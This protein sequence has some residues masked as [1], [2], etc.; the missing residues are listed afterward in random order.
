MRRRSRQARWWSGA[1]LLALAAC[2]SGPGPGNGDA[3]DASVETGDDG[4]APD[5]PADPRRI[6]A[7]QRPFPATAD[8]TTTNFFDH[9][10][11]REFID[12]NGRYVSY[13]GEDSVLGIDGH[14]GYDWRM[15]AGTS[16][17]AVMEGRV[18]AAG[19]S[20]PFDCPLLGK[21]VTD[22]RFVT[23]EHDLP[24]GV[25]VR[26][27]YIHLATIA[28]AA[29]AQVAAG[30]L[31][32]TVGASG[33]ALNPHLHF[34]VFRLTQT[35]SGQPAV[36]DPF[37]WSGAAADP[38]EADPAGAASIYLWRDGEAPPLYRRFDIPL[39][40]DA[41]DTQFVGITQIRFQGVDDAH[42]PNNEYVEISRDNRFAP[43]ALDLS[44]FTLK[45][46]AGDVF[47]FP[48]AFT[49]TAA[50]TSVRVFTGT[51]QNAESELYWGQSGPRLDNRA[52]CVQLFNAAGLLRTRTGWGGGCQ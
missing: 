49:L 44:G 1:T 31:I 25:R 47:T 41:G 22:Q 14:N 4:A 40:P 7:F 34:S 28:V 26:T 35:A 8:F 12:T 10:V 32:G 42:E 19:V 11:P 6:L 36:I 17:M 39:N 2:Q 16:V 23:I 48:A 18:V 51:G 38:W 37:G 15:D 13:W 5:V 50:R 52:D 46:K 45:N 27:Q 20:A 9:D 24:G 29:N 33:C 21:T 43:P 30:Q 3:S